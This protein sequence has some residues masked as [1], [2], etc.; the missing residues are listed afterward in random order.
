MIAQIHAKTLAFRTPGAKLIAV[1]DIFE[2]AGQRV[3][4]G[5]NGLPKFYKVQVAL[6]SLMLI[7][8]MATSLRVYRPSF[9][10]LSTPVHRICAGL[11]ASNF[12]ANLHVCIR[13]SC[14]SSFTT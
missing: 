4:D 1:S 6:I 14:S 7:S 10:V 8:L 2:E 3:V 12:H 5:C 13:L 11:K 9:R